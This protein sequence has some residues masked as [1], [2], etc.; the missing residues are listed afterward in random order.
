MNL[1]PNTS[2]T[3]KRGTGWFLMVNASLRKGRFLDLS[4]EAAAPPSSEPSS[5]LG[6]LGIFPPLV[7]SECGASSSLVHRVRKGTPTL[8][9][10]VIT[11]FLC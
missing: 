6:Q 11:L 10:T 1:A 7:H 9:N 8:V 5:P 3:K 2:H 4:Q